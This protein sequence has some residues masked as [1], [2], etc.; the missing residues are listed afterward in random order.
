MISRLVISIFA[1][2]VFV[3]LSA[4]M[5]SAELNP[6]A[7]TDLEKTRL[8]S[9]LKEKRYQDALNSI[10]A[11]RVLKAEL[12]RSVLYFEALAAEEVGEPLRSIRSIEKYIN[13]TV[14][15]ANDKYYLLSLEL[16]N[17]VEKDAL[18]AKQQLASKTSEEI[19][20]A[21]GSEQF[22]LARKILEKAAQNGLKREQVAA[23][24]NEIEVQQAETIRQRKAELARTMRLDNFRNRLE[25]SKTY[26]EK[27]FNQD[28][29][30]QLRW[31]TRN[32][33]YLNYHLFSL[34]QNLDW[35][36]FEDAHQLTC[37]VMI[38]NSAINVYRSEKD[39]IV[40]ADSLTT[41]DWV[42][43]NGYEKEDGTYEKADIFLNGPQRGGF[44]P[45]PELALLPIY[46]T[47]VSDDVKKS[48]VEGDLPDEFLGEI[49]FGLG[50][51]AI[52]HERYKQR[53]SKDLK[54]YW[55]EI[56][57]SAS[58]LHVYTRKEQAKLLYDAF[59]HLQ[60][61]CNCREGEWMDETK[62]MSCSEP[63]PFANKNIS[64]SDYSYESEVLSGSF[65]SEQAEEALRK[66]DE[67]DFADTEN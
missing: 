11:L 54:Y 33:G 17:R 12:P 16:Y 58:K 24:T 35:Q 59:K 40:Q 46:R 31:K 26:F 4:G 38:T 49:A 20:S 48:F 61:V 45:G 63:S 19:K 47:N 25:E 10:D 60:A 67:P 44:V 6:R 15:T 66:Q 32:D 52:T 5:A 34:S 22:G 2:S 42:Y 64:I 53:V 50:R 36:V 3:F 14:D 41:S 21:V 18:L 62:K 30:L 56:P 7:K 51:D 8:A 55:E 39:N 65:N 1:V 27:A 29:N 13:G 9:A 23:L 37:R 28:L 57:A 43:L